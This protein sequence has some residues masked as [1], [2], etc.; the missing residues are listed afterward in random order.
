[1][2]IDQFINLT[3]H[4]IT[5]EC[6]DQRQLTLPVSHTVARL[7]EQRRVVEG[8]QHCADSAQSY[9]I[10]VTQV[11]YGPTEDLPPPAAFTGY[12]VSQM[13][14]QANPHRDDLYFPGQLIRNGQGAIVGCRGLSQVPRPW[15]AHWGARVKAYWSP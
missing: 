15:W 1:M 12:V 10:D 5:I 8:L 2:I 11:A 6:T 14:A 3:P 13:V 9:T 7:R 4:P